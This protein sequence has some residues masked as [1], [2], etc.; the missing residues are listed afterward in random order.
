VLTA[1][2]L[3]VVVGVVPLAIAG[4]LWWRYGALA[5]G[6]AFFVAGCVLLGYAALLERVVVWLHPLR[7]RYC[8]IYDPDFWHQERLWKFHLS[9]PLQGTPFQV[10]IWRIAGLRVGHRV[11][12]DG[13]A[14]PEKALTTVGDDAVLNAGT[15]VQCHSL[16]DGYFVRDRATV[17]RSAVL[18]VNAFMHHGTTL[19]GGTVL[20]ADS[21]LLKGEQVAPGEHW[22]GNP[23][24][25]RRAVS[26]T[27]GRRTTHDG[28]PSRRLCH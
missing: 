17:G 7:P 3:G 16:E 28:R 11:F 5:L 18:G 26:S 24:S 27:P 2:C 19:G 12:D 14:F 13:C 21:Y 8:T 1:R 25:L 10:L 15:V 4:D 9:P 6:G 23:A 22:G 20:D